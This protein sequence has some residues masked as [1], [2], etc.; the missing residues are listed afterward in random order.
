MKLLKQIYHYTLGLLFRL[1]TC[2]SIVHK[3]WGTEYILVNND[4]YCCKLMGVR[5]GFVCSLHKHPKKHETF[6]V[7]GNGLEFFKQGVGWKSSEIGDTIEIPPQTWHQF[8][9]KPSTDV[10]YSWFLEVSTHD[11]PDDVV[12]LTESGE[13]IDVDAASNA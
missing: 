9:M 13:F 8:G 2:N 1:K 10:L 11:S 3:T 5:R 12:R 6:I 7:L 4:H